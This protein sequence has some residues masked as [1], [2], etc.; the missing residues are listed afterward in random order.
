MA[1]ATPA[2]TSPRPSASDGPIG[3]AFRVLQTVVATDEALGVREIGRRTGL[4][5]STASRLV[6]TLTDIGMLDRSPDGSVIAGTAIATLQLDPSAQ[7]SLL[8]DQLRPLLVELVQTFGENA[9]L[10]VDDGDAL[11][12]LLQ[13][14]SENPVSAPDLSA[15]RQ[16]FHLVAPGVVSMAWWPR[17]RLATHLAT[18]LETATGLSVIRPAAIRRRLKD[19]RRDG[20]VWTDQELDEGVNGL[21]VPIVRGGELLATISLYGPSYRFSAERRPELADELAQIV[22]DRSTSLL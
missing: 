8:R 4:P 6:A 13:I 19:V 22:T 7:P 3:R 18:T 12:Y 11:L 5:R 10:T 17:D 1:E 16:A 21:A 14:G 15:E 9:A 2:S 20:F